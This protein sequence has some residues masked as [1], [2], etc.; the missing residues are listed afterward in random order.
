M[1]VGVAQIVLNAVDLDQTCRQYLNRGWN[2]TFRVEALPNHPA[3]RTLQ[4]AERSVLDMVHLTPPEGISVE[5]TRYGGAAPAGEI[6]YEFDGHVLVRATEP[7][8]SHA[9]WHALGFAER[10]DGL[11]EIRALLP[12]WRLGVELRPY[13][14]ARPA[15]SVDAEGCVLV[16]LL[17]TAIAP[18]L[19]R[20]QATGLLLRFTTS[21]TEQVGSRKAVVAIVEGPSGELVELLEA[22]RRSG[23]DE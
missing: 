11:L 15:T 22:P 5:V 8:R 9:F 21:W 14:G 6:V 16:T 3:K 10:G 23:R 7:E 19:A 4:T 13:R 2:E 1:I 17:T 20:L 12:A 18:E